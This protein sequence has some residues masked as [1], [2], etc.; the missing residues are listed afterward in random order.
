MRIFLALS[1][2]LM[3][4]SAFAQQVWGPNPPITRPIVT[5]A[6]LPACAAVTKGFM[7]FVTDSLT[8]VAL[9]IVAGGGAVQ[10]G[11]LCNGTNWI[12]Q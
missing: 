10:I 7:Y 2:W 6:T 5:V 3:S 1:I 8:P 11:V 12:V 4:T 9:A